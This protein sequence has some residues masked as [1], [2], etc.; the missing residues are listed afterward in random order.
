MPILVKSDLLSKLKNDHLEITGENNNRIS[1]HELAD[2]YNRYY[3]ERNFTVLDDTARDEGKRIGLKWD[4]QRKLYGIKGCFLG[5][6]I[7]D[8]SINVLPD[9]AHQE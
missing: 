2:L 9:P 6:K 3:S 4:C 7:K 5:V 1:K 8:V